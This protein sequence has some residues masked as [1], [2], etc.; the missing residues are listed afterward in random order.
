MTTIESFLA[1]NWL[2]LSIAVPLLAILGTAAV[3]YIFSM[4]TNALNQQS[5]NNTHTA[6]MK[7][8]MAYPYLGA[9]DRQLINA[10]SARISI[11]SA[12]SI[13]ELVNSAGGTPNQAEAKNEVA[14]S[15]RQLNRKIDTLLG[16][17]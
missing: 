6:R 5:I 12:N 16:R 13:D 10:T 11:N 17:K 9:I 15:N 8:E 1:D 3:M 7:A 2:V 4:A 14:T